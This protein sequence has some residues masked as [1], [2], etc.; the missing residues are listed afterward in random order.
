MRN[1]PRRYPR[2][3]SL[4]EGSKASGLVAVPETNTLSTP[5]DVVIGNCRF[6]YD[7]PQTPVN[8]RTGSR[9]QVLKR[10]G[11]PSRGD[12]SSTALR[13][14]DGTGVDAALSRL[15]LRTRLMRLLCA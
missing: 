1:L 4:L 8:L 11:R 15:E 10:A 13:C 12:R 6:Q 9:Q 14:A 2:A 3:A 7:R 5:G